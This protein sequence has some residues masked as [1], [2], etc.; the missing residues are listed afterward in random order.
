MP[1]F[2]ILGAFHG[3]VLAGLAPEWIIF[4]LILRAGVEMAKGLVNAH[5]VSA[6][7][8]DGRQ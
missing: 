1:Y 3:G 7:E 5:H 4:V 2:Y 8:L 6:L